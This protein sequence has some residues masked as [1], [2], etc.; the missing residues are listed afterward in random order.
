MSQCGHGHIIVVQGMGHRAISQR[1]L[2]GGGLKTTGDNRSLRGA[3]HLFD[4]F[5]DDPGQG[6]LRAGQNTTQAIKDCPLG[7]AHRLAGD[8]V[9][10]GPHNEVGDYLCG[11]DSE[12]PPLSTNMVNLSAR[13]ALAPKRI[14]AHPAK[15]MNS[16]RPGLS[17]CRKA[18][19]H[20]S[21]L[22][23]PYSPKASLNTPHISPMVT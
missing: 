21:M 12:K 15:E 1:C 23:A 9:V 18:A 8:L 17:E 10:A 2:G 11:A 4:I 13:G 7:R 14:V 6:L 20:T 3:P 5:G 22:Y 19:F 16:Y